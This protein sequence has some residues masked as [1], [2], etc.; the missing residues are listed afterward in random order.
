MVVK[1]DSIEVAAAGL[2]PPTHSPA[3]EIKIEAELMRI[4]ARQLSAVLIVVVVIAGLATYVMW[5]SVPHDLLLAWASAL[6][7]LALVRGAI[8]QRLMR[9]KLLQSDEQL[10]RVIPLLIGLTIVGSSLWGLGA[11]LVVTTSDSLV[12]RVLIAFVCGGM[13]AGSMAG[14][15]A[16]ARIFYAALIPNLGVAIIVFLAVD[17]PSNRMM[18]VMLAVFGAALIYFGRNVRRAIAQSVRLRFE[19]SALVERLAGAR[20]AAEALVVERTQALQ[21]VNQEL[22]KRIAER[23]AAENVAR[24]SEE[25][26]R[27]IVQ[28]MP[29][30]MYAVDG[31]GNFIVWNRECHQ[32]TGYAPEAIVGNPDGL[33]LLYPDDGYREKIRRSILAHSDYRDWES[34]IECADGSVRT[35]SWFNIS[36]S[37]AVPGWAGWGMGVDITERARARERLEEALAKERELG[38]LKSRFIAMASHEFRTPLTTIQASVDLLRRYSDRMSEA[39]KQDNLVSIRREIVTLT[40]LLDGILTIG[41]AEAGRLDFEPRGLD[42]RS[43]AIDLI[44]KAKLTARPDHSFV[45]NCVGSCG[46]VIA[47]E[48]LIRHMLSNL[49]S[50]AV[51]YSPKGGPITIHLQCDGHQIALSVADK[52]IGIPATGREYVFE[53]FHR[54]DNVGAISGTG[55]GLAIVKRAVERHNGQIAVDSQTGVGTTFRIALPNGAPR[56]STEPGGARSV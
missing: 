39:Q 20:E 17:A 5:D 21:E 8:L 29:V 23:I 35:I 50:N 16:L 45:F 14:L 1:E 15:S 25:R 9:R 43:L 54:F 49:L 36:R 2:A 3:F 46:A 42:L 31:N 38:E 10:H 44:E 48:Q 52:G 11:V 32:V 41:R 24:Q 33:S 13:G 37:F 56:Q 6:T 51:K 4:S 7:V 19:N 26:L 12:D 18:G 40:E 55:L 30:M 22:G 27:H 34:Q 28:N 47:D 53:A